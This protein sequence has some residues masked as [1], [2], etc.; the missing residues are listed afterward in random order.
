M[1]YTKGMDYDTAAREALKTRFKRHHRA[2]KHLGFSENN[3]KIIWSEVYDTGNINDKRK[4]YG[5]MRGVEHLEE[6]KW[7]NKGLSANR[8]VPRWKLP[9]G[10]KNKD[11]TKYLDLAFERARLK[12]PGR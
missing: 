7:A 6:A 3:A 12:C 2:A 8:K 10:V 1:H 5:T 4:A 11:I 9:I